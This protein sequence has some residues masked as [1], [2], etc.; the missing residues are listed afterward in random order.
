MEDPIDNNRKDKQINNDDDDTSNDI[1]DNNNK[2]KIIKA[3]HFCFSSWMI[4]KET[5]NE[6]ILITKILR[7]IIAI[8]IR[9]TNKMVIIQS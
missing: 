9:T 7:M 5:K 1:T 3:C 6:I 2:K 4:M 8:V